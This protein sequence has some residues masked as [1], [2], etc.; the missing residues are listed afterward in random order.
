MWKKINQNI[1]VKV[2]VDGQPLQTELTDVEEVMSRLWIY[3]QNWTVNNTWYWEVWNATEEETKLLTDY[4][5]ALWLETYSKNMSCHSEMKDFVEQTKAEIL[6]EN[7][8]ETVVE[9]PLEQP[10]TNDWDT[11]ETTW[12]T[13]QVEWA[14]DAQD[15]VWGQD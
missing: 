8:K 1:T 9:Q 5:N 4:C 3:V 7:A 15:V 12:E 11:K 13:T 14:K 10:S 6:A 2:M